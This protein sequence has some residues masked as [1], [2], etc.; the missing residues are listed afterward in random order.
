VSGLVEWANDYMVKPGGFW[1][2]Q[3][4]EP[5]PLGYDIYDDSDATDEDRMFALR[6]MAQVF[7][8]R[9][10]Y[11]DIAAKAVAAALARQRHTVRP[12]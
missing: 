3:P 8:D 12:T 2:N 11:Y 10:D 6:L 7:A 9:N 4:D 5:E 1:M